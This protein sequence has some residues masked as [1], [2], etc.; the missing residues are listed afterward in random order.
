MSE[1]VVNTLELT[2]RLVETPVPAARRRR[3]WLAWW[4]WA[5]FGAAVTFSGTLAGTWTAVALILTSP[6]WVLF[7]L[8]PLF[9]IR[10]RLRAKRLWAAEV[11]VLLAPERRGEAE[12]KTA[13]PVIVGRAGGLLVPLV[14]WESA[15]P[16]LPPDELGVQTLPP[17]RFAGV[18]L[19][20]LEA[21][22]L[23]QTPEL[24]LPAADAV[25][26]PDREAAALWVERLRAARRSTGLPQESPS[27]RWGRNAARII[28]MKHISVRI[29]SRR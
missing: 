3:F 28:K 5:V 20:V 10:D 4:L 7:V 14:A 29:I 17:G 8:W 12:E 26:D 25:V 1:E 19:P 22:A 21:E 24:A 9:W 16:A 11:L 13:L 23:L 27:F 18:K 15:F 6:F 2:E